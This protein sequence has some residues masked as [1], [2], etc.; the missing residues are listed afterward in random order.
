VTPAEL[1]GRQEVVECDLLFAELVLFFSCTRLNYFLSIYCR[2]EVQ[3]LVFDK[4]VLWSLRFLTLRFLAC[5]IHGLQVADELC[6]CVQE[7]LCVPSSTKS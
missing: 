4:Q 6:A 2:N 1:L 5:F 7:T 3:Y